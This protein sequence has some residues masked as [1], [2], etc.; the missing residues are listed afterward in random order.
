MCGCSGDSRKRDYVFGAAICAAAVLN[1]D[2][3]PVRRIEYRLALPLRLK[4]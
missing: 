1:K 2:N 3:R 4:S